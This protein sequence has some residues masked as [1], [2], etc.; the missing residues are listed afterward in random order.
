MFLVGDITDKTQS[1]NKSHYTRRALWGWVVK[2]T[3]SPLKHPNICLNPWIVIVI[4]CLS[5]VLF[6]VHCVLI[7]CICQYARCRL[8]SESSDTALAAADTESALT[9]DMHVAMIHCTFHCWLYLRKIHYVW[10]SHSKCSTFR[11]WGLKM[12]AGMSN[13][14]EIPSNW[15]DVQLW[16]QWEIESRINHSSG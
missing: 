5:G 16:T 8:V 14:E 4:A 7:D 9:T 15:P 12:K 6:L 1:K 2:L 10:C 11:Q 13:R 3:W